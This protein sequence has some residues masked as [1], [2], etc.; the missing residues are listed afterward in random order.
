MLE[1]LEYAKEEYIRRYVEMQQKA[2]AKLP[3]LEIMKEFAGEV[4]DSHNALRV[5]MDRLESLQEPE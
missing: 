4:W 5:E 3:P 2:G 1:P